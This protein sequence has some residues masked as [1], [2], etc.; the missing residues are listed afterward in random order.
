MPAC[1]SVAQTFWTRPCSLQN[2]ALARSILKNRRSILIF[3]PK[4]GD[5][6]FKVVLLEGS[7]TERVAPLIDENCAP[8]RDILKTQSFAYSTT[9]HKLRS[10]SRQSRFF[11]VVMVFISSKIAFPC[12]AS[13]KFRRF[14]IIKFDQNEAPVW[15]IRKIWVIY[16]R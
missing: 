9:T 5:F 3:S 8:V 13:S 16:E 10:R 4:K 15:S 14:I 1:S 6:A 7:P 2:R 12:A 11:C